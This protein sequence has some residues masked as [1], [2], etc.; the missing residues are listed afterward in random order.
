MWKPRMRSFHRDRL[1]RRPVCKRRPS[2]SSCV[3]P[4]SCRIC[5]I[6]HVTELCCAR[7]NANA[8]DR[9]WRENPSLPSTLVSVA[10]GNQDARESFPSP[11][12]LALITLC[13]PSAGLRSRTGKR[14][15][16]FGGRARGALCRYLPRI[17]LQTSA[18]LG[19]GQAY[20]RQS[21]WPGCQCFRE[22]NIRK[23]CFC[24]MVPKFFLFFPVFIF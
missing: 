14:G 19:S 12:C 10:L 22:E 9:P 15:R 20:E 1:W 23:S 24:Q 11:P 16:L 2:S 21:S 13:S 4:A 18:A 8:S 5:R 3:T 17:I 6:R 7:L